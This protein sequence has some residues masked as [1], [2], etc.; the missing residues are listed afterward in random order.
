MT[1][2]HDRGGDHISSPGAKGRRWA[3]DAAAVVGPWVLVGGLA[4]LLGTQDVSP[5]QVDP[6]PATQSLPEGAFQTQMREAEVFCRTVELLREQREIKE[7]EGQDAWYAWMGRTMEA[8]QCHYVPPG[9]IAMAWLAYEFGGC[10]TPGLVGCVVHI[11]FFINGV[12][13][14]RVTFFESLEPAGG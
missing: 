9:V 2:R 1:T 14:D 6:D 13:Y 3:E 7:V 5:Q 12:P 8:G 4:W 11:R 10:D